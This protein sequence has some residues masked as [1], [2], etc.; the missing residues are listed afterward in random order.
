MTTTHAPRHK[1]VSAKLM[2]RF[3][4]MLAL[5]FAMQGLASA[6]TLFSTFDASNSIDPGGMLVT[7]APPDP[8]SR[9]IRVGFQ[10]FATISAYVQ[11]DTFDSIQ[12]ALSTTEDMS[13]H[14]EQ[15][16]Y[17]SMFEDVA[18]VPGTEVAGA[19]VYWPLGSTPTLFRAN[20]GYPF[21]LQLSTSR[22]YWFGLSLRNGFDGSFDADRTMTWHFASGTQAP[23][24]R[25]I[26]QP[27]P[28]PA[29]AVLVLVGLLAAQARLRRRMSSKP[30]L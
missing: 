28:E 13:Q 7:G 22:F 1:S 14:P 10:A 16:V 3:A 18:G 19:Y 24:L 9:G 20:S 15:T 6:D 23:G 27:V 2:R 8:A 29:S 4:T 17:M 30:P 21:S 5:L 26:G 11:L 12:Y 25:L